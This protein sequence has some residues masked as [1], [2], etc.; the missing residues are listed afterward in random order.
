MLESG[1]TACDSVF[2][3]YQLQKSVAKSRKK[4]WYFTAL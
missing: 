1:V 2:D 4:W 3:N